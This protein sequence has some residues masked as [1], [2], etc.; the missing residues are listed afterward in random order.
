MRRLLLVALNLSLPFILF[1]LRNWYWRY[2]H[3]TR[4]LPKLD[5]KR[6][7]RLL[8]WGILLLFITMLATR[9]LAPTDTPFHGNDATTQDY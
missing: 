6:I 8:L 1:A 4:D 3:P 2:K 9:A 7:L 5:T